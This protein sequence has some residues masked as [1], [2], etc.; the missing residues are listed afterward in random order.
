MHSTAVCRQLHVTNALVDAHAFSGL[1]SQCHGEAA[2]AGC[3]NFC[4]NASLPLESIP[5]HP[6]T[7]WIWE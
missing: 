5:S 2:R 7:E 1:S 4:G 6:S 3:S